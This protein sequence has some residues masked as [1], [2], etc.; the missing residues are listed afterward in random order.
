MT[1][2]ETRCRAMSLALSQLSVT[3]A[4]TAAARS[5]IRRGRCHHPRVDAVAEPWRCVSRTAVSGSSVRV[6]VRV[7]LRVGVRHETDPNTDRSWHL[8]VLLMAFS[9][10][11]SCAP[12]DPVGSSSVWGIAW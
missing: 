4:D 1:G 8:S 7:D 2:H 9:D 11:L 6:E 5:H 3:E 10:E 12:T